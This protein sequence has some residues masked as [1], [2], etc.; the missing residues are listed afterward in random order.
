MKLQATLLE[1]LKKDIRI[2]PLCIESGNKL[3][4]MLNGD[5]INPKLASQDANEITIQTW[6]DENHFDT[7][8]N[9]YG[10]LLGNEYNLFC[11]DIDLK[12]LEPNMR[13]IFYSRLRESVMN[14]DPKLWKTLAQTSIN[15]TSA[16][17]HHYFRL[18]EEYNGPNNPALLTHN[19]KAIVELRTSAYAASYPSPGYIVTDGTPEDFWN[20]IP[21]LTP[22]DLF[23]LRTACLRFENELNPKETKKVK[24]K[25]S[26]LK[27]MKPIDHFNR[28]ANVLLMLEDIGYTKDYHSN[29]FEIRVKHPNSPS[30]KT[31]GAIYLDHEIPVYVEYAANGVF[32]E[33][34]QKALKPHQVF[35][36]INDL[37]PYEYKKINKE[38]Y[39]HGYGSLFNTEG[40]KMHYINECLSEFCEKEGIYFNTFSNRICTEDGI[41]IDD[42]HLARGYEYLSSQNIK[43]SN[44]ERLRFWNNYLNFK[45]INPVFGYFNNCVKNYNGEDEFAKMLK[46][47]DFENKNKLSKYLKKFLIQIVAQGLHS[48]TSS[49]EGLQTELILALYSK[50]HG[51]GKTRFFFEFLRQNIERYCDPKFSHKELEQDLQFA[52]NILVIDDEASV[53]SRK[54]IER[55]KSLVSMRTL[56]PTLKYQNYA[57][58]LARRAVL[59]ITSNKQEIINDT[60]NRRMIALSIKNIDIDGLM[61]NVNIDNLWGQLGLI[62]VKDPSCI[63]VKPKDIIQLN[64]NTE[65][66]KIYGELD[67][68]LADLFTPMPKKRYKY[69]EVPF[70]YSCLRRTDIVTIVETLYPQKRFTKFD[71]NRAFDKLGYYNWKPKDPVTKEQRSVYLLIP[72]SKVKE[73]EVYKKYTEL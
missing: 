9:G 14:I 36:V 24:H 19:N 31:S 41:P 64:S 44:E 1:L 35:A 26:E 5:F 72:K 13:F 71:Y 63:Y 55:M 7:P 57:K 46:Y 69:N 47:M 33:Y 43:T 62:W 70:E 49:N 34:R 48:E 45:Q 51:R 54:E 10:L 8:A 37:N 25:A 52:G 59:G 42:G 60:F 28:V 23:N 3:P 32:A 67:E 39:V 56:N 18:T 11:L 6:Y 65:D 12:H 66:F 27:K 29:E 40:E 50:E 16:G 68:I 2:T 22:L 4:P 30:T 20:Y 53:L 38:L 73:T 21:T 61:K 17:Y 15:T 58:Y